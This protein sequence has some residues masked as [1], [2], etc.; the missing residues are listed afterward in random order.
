MPGHV[1]LIEPALAGSRAPGSPTV[2]KLDFPY[3][4]CE[5][6]ERYLGGLDL[7]GSSASEGLTAAMRYSLLAGGKRIR[8]VLVLATARALGQQWRE[9]LP[10]AA[11][12]EL[13]HT[14]TLIHDDLPAMDDDD[15]RRGLPTN[16]RAFGE[17][18]AILAGDALFAEGVQLLLEVNA[19]ADR[20]LAAA[21]VVTRAVGVRGLAAGQY[22]D[23][24]GTAVDD[25]SVLEM[26]RLKTG[27]LL[28]A[29]VEAVLELARPPRQ[30]RDG[31]LVYAAELGVMFQIVDDILDVTSTSAQTG[32]SHGSD[33]RNGR[34]TV[35]VDGAVPKAQRLA[36][37]HLE[38]IGAAL[39]PL[40]CDTT[41]LLT[42]AHYIRHRCG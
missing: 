41:E 38:R 25:A 31:L 9:V 26:H 28:Q 7:A 4:L 13:I 16:H 23:I 8:P 17:G 1:T 22:I 29:C 3:G 39:A 30:V 37:A 18:V 11:A 12:V 40:P 6:V 27:A 35:V 36:D 20:T 19:P 21:R 2:G 14:F 32:K 5:E 15:L 42:I 34:R 10:L 24:S 33:E